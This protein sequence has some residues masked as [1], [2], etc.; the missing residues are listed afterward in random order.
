M[1]APL[2][3]IA[4]ICRNEEKVLPRLIASLKPYMDAGG[5]INILDT[6][7]KDSSVSLAK[8]LGCNV[9]EVG[10]KYLIEITNY[11]AINQKF[12]VTGEPQ[13]VKKGDKYFHFSKARNHAASLCAKDFVFF[14]DCDEVSVSMDIEKINQTIRYFSPTSTTL[15]PK[16]F[17]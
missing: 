8:S 4:L 11:M 10:E 14:Y 13:V 7:S 15:Q 3:S 6:G 9:V 16:D 12:V 5:D 2:F 1:E 17:A